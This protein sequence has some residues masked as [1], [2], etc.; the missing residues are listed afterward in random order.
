MYCIGI[1]LVQGGP[2]ADRYKW[3]YGALING[4]INGKLVIFHPTYKGYLDVPGS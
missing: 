1:K 2:R 3:S 4:L